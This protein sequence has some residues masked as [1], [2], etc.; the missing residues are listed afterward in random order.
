MISETKLSNARAKPLIKKE[1][2]D[3][4]RIKGYNYIRDPFGINL[5]CSRRKSGKTIAMVS[6]VLATISR[7]TFV[8]VITPNSTKDD[9]IIEFL[10]TLTK[11]DISHKVLPGLFDGKIDVLE[12]IIDD[13]LKPEDESDEDLPLTHV[14]KSNI[15]T[16]K[17][18]GGSY[19]I[20][21]NGKKTAQY[22]TTKP[23]KEVKKKYTPKKISPEI[24]I[25]IDD[26]ATELNHSTGGL[27]SLAYNGRHLKIA[28]HISFQS[29]SCLPPKIWEQCSTIF[30]FKNFS[31]IKLEAIFENLN[32]PGVE[33][34]DF[35]KIYEYAT[36]ITPKE[37][38]PFL[39]VDTDDGIFRRNFNKQIHIKNIEE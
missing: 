11:R 8:W 39:L 24:C 33:F 30:I 17:I 23:K 29:K 37:N 18:A 32:L 6:A 26:C 2:I 28:A 38:H 34:E 21:D 25:L 20:L 15:Q 36:K 27:G 22:S 31:K 13:L 14:V 9:N 19:K 1:P 7:H 35:L 4:S 12:K 5:Y 10:N 16:I 3:S